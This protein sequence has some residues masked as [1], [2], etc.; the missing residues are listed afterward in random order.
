MNSDVRAIAARERARVKEPRPPPKSILRQTQN[1][2]SIQISDEVFSHI[3]ASD[4]E[5]RALR[6]VRK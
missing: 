2:K 3:I 5:G 1:T 6:P 4:N